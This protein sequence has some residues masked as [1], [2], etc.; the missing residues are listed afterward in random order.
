MAYITVEKIGDFGVCRHKGTPNLYVSAYIAET[1]SM[2]YRS[3]HTASMENACIQVRGLV[4]RGVTGDPAEA[5]VQKPRSR[6][7][8][9][10]TGRRLKSRPLRSS[11]GS[12][13]IA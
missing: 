4:D 12:L 1:G 6:R 7:F 8:L 9:N 2:V 10:S 5:L 13:S 11:A 3:L